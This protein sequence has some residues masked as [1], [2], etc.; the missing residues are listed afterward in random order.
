MSVVLTP[1]FRASAAAKL[2]LLAMA[3]LVSL[4][5]IK[6]IKSLTVAVVD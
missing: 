3:L 4:P 5:L 6:E 2:T 1:D